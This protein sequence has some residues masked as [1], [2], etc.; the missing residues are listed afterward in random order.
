MIAPTI[1]RRSDP[2]RAPGSLPATARPRIHTWSSPLG[3][4]WPHSNSIVWTNAGVRA[5]GAKAYFFE[6]GTTTPRST[7][8]DADLTTPHAHPVVADGN[9]RFP[10]IFLDFG[11]Y[12]ERIRT[13][14]D[15][16]LWDTDQIPNP[17]PLDEAIGVDTDALLQTGQFVF[18][19]IDGTRTG[20]VRANGRTIGSAM[21]GASERANAD[22]R[23]P[24]HAALQRAVEH[25][26]PRFDRARR[27]RRRGFRGEQDARPARSARLGTSRPRHDGQQRGVALRRIGAVQ[28]RQRD[29][30]RQRR[31]RQSRHARYDD[32][33]EPYA[34]VLADHRSG[35][36]AYPYGDHVERWRPH[37]HDHDHRSGARP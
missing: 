28:R 36:R 11:S 31:G 12:R 19:L 20:F 9:G 35:R 32:D 13:S 26:L 30:S 29:D 16:T 1:S 25:G 5:A 3:I 37:P 27:E 6:A 24:L 10:A 18:E 15:T 2:P 34:H 14:A 17:A 22:T 23:R 4:L 33:P 7:Y 21:S 8:H